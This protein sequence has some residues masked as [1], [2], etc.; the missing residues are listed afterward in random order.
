ME[1]GHGDAEQGEKG[2]QIPQAKVQDEGQAVLSGQRPL[3][4]VLPAMQW[5]PLP[6]G[7]VGGANS[8]QC[9]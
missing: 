4:G 1:G 9:W 7:E 3:M 5:R 2:L 8:D 6:Q